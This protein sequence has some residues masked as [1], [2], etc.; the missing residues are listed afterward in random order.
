ML[1][2]GASY[3]K[4]LMVVWL[5][6][7]FTKFDSVVESFGFDNDTHDKQIFH[8]FQTSHVVISILQ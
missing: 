3:I 2:F 4:D 8:P 7:T 6:L 5:L 1:G